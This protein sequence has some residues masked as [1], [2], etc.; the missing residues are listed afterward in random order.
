[1]II[2]IALIPAL[3]VFLVAATTANKSTTTVAALIA[4]AIGV[5]TGNPIYMALDV[6]CV[7]VV[8]WFSM[9]AMEKK[10]GLEKPVLASKPAITVS[11][12]DS[13]PGSTIAILGGLGFM[14]YLI[15]G[16]SSSNRPLVQPTMP[17]IIQPSTASTT[18]PHSPTQS[19]PTPHSVVVKAQPKHTEK[20]PLMQ[21]VEIE[22]EEKMIKCLGGLN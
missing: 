14:V 8:Y 12:N 4:A 5:F 3:G 17:A 19:A 7:I 22:S 13:N 9:F 20:S 6:G 11:N 16:S 1:M 10:S 18:K 21:C 2:L 15:F